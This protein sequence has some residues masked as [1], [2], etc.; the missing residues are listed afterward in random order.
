MVGLNRVPLISQRYPWWCCHL[1]SWRHPII[2]TR[3]SSCRKVKTLSSHNSSSTHSSTPCRDT[4]VWNLVLGH[5][6]WD[7]NWWSW[8]NLEQRVGCFCTSFVLVRHRWSDCPVQKITVSDFWHGR[9]HIWR[10]IGSW[11]LAICPYPY[12]HMVCDGLSSPVGYYS[13]YLSSNT[14]LGAQW[15]V[16][17]SISH[18]VG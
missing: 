17:W 15:W 18:Q 3:R 7:G 9:R 2:Q 5:Y 16:V 8:L 1:T 14:W 11:I 4:S 6:N 13:V 12:N 10:R